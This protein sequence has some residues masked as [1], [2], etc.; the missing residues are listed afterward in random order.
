MFEIFKLFFFNLFDTS[1]IIDLFK[2]IN[3]ISSDKYFI[4]ISFDT[5]S[6]FLL[7]STVI[8]LTIICIIRF[9]KLMFPVY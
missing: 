8:F 3:F 7:L 4:L 2:Q 1:L 6:I 9:S 5:N